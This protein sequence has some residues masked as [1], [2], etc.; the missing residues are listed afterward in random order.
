[1]IKELIQKPLEHALSLLWLLSVLHLLARLQTHEL[2]LQLAIVSSL[3]ALVAAFLGCRF[4]I[5]FF[6][7][8]P[9]LL[10][11][12]AVLVWARLLGVGGSGLT[13]VS[14]VFAALTW[15]VAESVMQQ[16]S[17]RRILATIGMR[18]EH[19][20]TA[21]LSLT[22]N[23]TLLV[24]T[25]V[26]V[27]LQLKQ[28]G[29]LDASASHDP[30]LLLTLLLATWQLG[31]CSDSVP[32]GAFNRY[33]TLLVATL[34]FL[35]L[36]SLTVH[37]VCLISLNN[38]PLA[39]MLLIAIGGVMTTLTHWLPSNPGRRFR[40]PLLM[41]ATVF[42]ALGCL[43]HAIQRTE[44]SYVNTSSWD[45]LV[46]LLGGSL[47]LAS[48][49]RLRLPLINGFAMIG[50]VCSW[51]WL[52]FWCLH[53]GK[54]FPL[55]PDDQA[56][57]DQ[58]LALILASLILGGL[59]GW[60]SHHLR[61]FQQ[62]APAWSGAALLCYGWVL[63]G[64]LQMTFGQPLPGN[65]W[66]P[67]IWAC[68]I[69]GQFLVLP[70]F[71]LVREVRGIAIVLLSVLL[72]STSLATLQLTHFLSLSLGLAAWM[73][74]LSAKHLL[75]RFNV[76]FPQWAISTTVWPWAGLLLLYHC[77]FQVKTDWS[78]QWPWLMQV[79]IYQLLLRNRFLDLPAILSLVLGLLWLQTTQL[80]PDETF[81]LLP[82][83]TVS[84]DL[85]LTLSL[86]TWVFAVA[87]R[88]RLAPEIAVYRRPFRNAAQ[89]G[90][91]WTLAGTLPLLAQTA[92]DSTVS[93][94]IF[95]ILCSALY[96]LSSPAEQGQTSRSIPSAV[97]LT[98]SVVV[99]SY[100]WKLPILAILPGWSYCLLWLSVYAIPSFNQRYRVYCLSAE[101]WAWTGFLL[102]VANALLLEQL[103]GAITGS[104]FFVLATYTVM[105]HRYSGTRLL[106][107][108][109]TGSF[110]AS[111]FAFAG[112][113]IASPKVQGLDAVIQS[114]FG[115]VGIVTLLWANLMLWLGH[116]WQCNRAQWQHRWQWQGDDLST[117]FSHSALALILGWLVTLGYTVLSLRYLGDVPVSNDS[118]WC[119]MATGVVL[120]L[121]CLH[122]LVRLC[123]PLTAHGLLASLF[124]L[125]WSAHFAI[126]S[127]LFPAT[128]IWLFWSATLIL[129]F[130]VLS[131][132]EWGQFEVHRLLRE[133][134]PYW[135]NGS[136]L[137]AHAALPVN[138][139][140]ISSECLLNLA[141]LI[142]VT[143]SWS[144]PFIK[145]SWFAAACLELLIF[146]HGW[147]L[148]WIPFSKL[149]SLYP[150]YA[151]QSIILSWAFLLR[152]ERAE[153]NSQRQALLQQLFRSWSWL[154]AVAVLELLAHILTLKQ[155]LESGS[156]PQWLLLPV[157]VIATFATGLLIVGMGIRLLKDKPDSAW[158]YGMVGV[159]VSL[160]YYLRL[161]SVG[162]SA[163]GPWDTSIL[164]LSAYLLG[165]IHR[166]VK[167]RPLF[168][169]ALLMPVLALFT[170][171][172]QFESGPA[173]LTLWATGG[174]YLLVRQDTKRQLPVYL[175]LLAFNAGL[176]LW[177]PGFVE[178]SHLLQLY[179]MPA[180]ISVLVLLQLHRNDLRNKELMASRLAAVTVLYTSATLDV[181]LQAG[182]SI[183]ILAMLLSFA[184]V[185]I[186]I[187][188][189]VRAYLYAG[190]SF[191]LLNVV[192]Q[193]LR[194]Y[195]EQM[196][197]KAIF[198]MVAGAS[199]IAAM[200]WFNLKR[201]EIMR[202]FDNLQDALQNWD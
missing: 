17:V 29:L 98:L 14:V 139:A 116:Y 48:N 19:L 101:S 119:L 51:Q 70:A 88:T 128:S 185:L 201:A 142:L 36:L 58:W 163:A 148:L 144:L 151:L 20:N 106:A 149:A 184:G 170:V 50:L 87:S 118:W 95:L 121:S 73:F 193:F 42:I 46:L 129:V 192:G 49:S 33:L 154:L 84:G 177:I 145:A 11:L 112:Q 23:A 22:A 68:V 2:T 83:Q 78:D 5:R 160:G 181:Y 62:T 38:D 131:N 165:L 80:H 150:F 169:S 180:A 69:V 41:T 85:W 64:A 12:N 15:A 74:W 43:L 81:S 172:L 89:L 161:V 55:W 113:F 7:L 115:M 27:W 171:P 40:K 182:I 94:W 126:A 127:P 16:A 164:I 54:P 52:W 132:R 178:N 103:T 197:A 158:V 90:F 102:I 176:Y 67:V 100:H 79:A 136:L 24:I 107:W 60:L 75:P 137:G 71:S 186:G 37:P 91:I 167:S 122:A 92:H 97:L 6:I 120:S 195:P 202:R 133:I 114:L 26:A 13:L 104:Y 123:Q 56:Y 153:H 32:W 147:P 47:L 189:R 31:C 166:F 146:L 125:I 63:L 196:L 61:Y 173:S 105:M 86:F 135:I 21:E 25:D 93:A 183:F 82:L 117:A 77:L 155:W 76:L 124:I 44:L 157:D 10:A 187:A 3:A 198:M 57:S 191:M 134:F 110:T 179:V 138:C 9:L 194:F 130:A 159:M 35:E 18:Y 200:V 4:Q 190:T 8:L 156:A 30:M 99:W 53:P 66:L 141:L 174:L 143:T 108:L 175:A 152:T 140:S 39:G 45:C 59:S 72:V 65:Y 34:A 111:C 168:H 28:S 162:L 188:L 1:M 199:I 109:V 96:P